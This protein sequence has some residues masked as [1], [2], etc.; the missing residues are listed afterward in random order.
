VIA[1]FPSAGN[2]A[3]ALDSGCSGDQNR[4]TPPSL[5]FR[6]YSAEDDYISSSMNI[7]ENRS[8]AYIQILRI[9]IS[10]R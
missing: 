4:A 5:S 9:H 8:R 2:L 6:S 3:P 1:T 10:E 7:N